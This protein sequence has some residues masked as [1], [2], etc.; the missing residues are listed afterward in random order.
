[1]AELNTEAGPMLRIEPDA[2][3]SATPGAEAHGSDGRV[4][5]HAPV[6]SDTTDLDDLT[7]TELIKYVGL[8]TTA[9]LGRPIVIGVTIVVVFVL[10]G[11]LLLISGGSDFFT[12][13]AAALMGRSRAGSSRGRIP[14]G[15]RFP[16]SRAWKSRDRPKYHRKFRAVNAMRHFRHAHPRRRGH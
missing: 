2:P 4:S 9:M 3:G 5:P 1:M 7:V 15:T 13:I 16:A 6:K 14:V 12:D 11:R 10:L 8:D